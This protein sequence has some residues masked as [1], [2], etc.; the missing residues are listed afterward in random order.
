MVS[1]EQICCASLR[2][3][4]SLRVFSYRPNKFWTF[5]WSDL[6]N[7]N[8]SRPGARR[9]ATEVSAVNFFTGVD[10]LPLG[11]P[12]KWHEVGD[13]LV[14]PAHCRALILGTGAHLIVTRTPRSSSFI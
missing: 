4:S 1:S 7:V 10:F 14:S 6:S 5:S 2:F 3:I 13:R 8:T 11:T 9:F 12:R